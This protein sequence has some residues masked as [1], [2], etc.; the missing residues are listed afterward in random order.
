MLR[1]FSETSKEKLL[2]MVW[3]VENDEIC[4][5]TDWIGDRWCDYEDWL[6]DLGLVGYINDINAYHKKVIDKNNATYSAINRIF[7]EVNNV[8]V[9][10]WGIF[11]NIELL[12]EEQRI[13][14]SELSS[15]V[16]PKNKK[17]NTV[18][19]EHQLSDGV[20]NIKCLSKICKEEND[21]TEK[22]VEAFRN[23]D[24][25]VENYWSVFTEYVGN[26]AENYV[27]RFEEYKSLPE[28]IVGWYE[29]FQEDLY[30]DYDNLKSF[31]EDV[32]TERNWTKPNLLPDDC[33]DFFD[34]LSDCQ[35]I[36]DIAKELE[37]Y[38]QTGDGWKAYKEIGLSI[39][40]K[41]V[42]EGNKWL[43]KVDNLKY[44]GIDKQIQSVLVDTIIKMP[45]KYIDGIINYAENGVGTAGSIVVDSTVGALLESTGD[46]AKPIY[47]AST[48]VTYPVVDQI[49]EAVGY[50]LSS[51]Y[52]R[53]TGK[54]GLEGVFS[55]QKELWVD[56]V[57]EGAM[58]KAGQLV[59]DFYEG[60]GKGWK[61]WKSGMKLI[62]GRK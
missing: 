16:T 27:K 20:K 44:I 62:F 57:Y 50:D 21:A 24:S 29:W 3:Q 42:K 34:T 51:E 30:E 26:K 23:T 60:V 11:H 35:L 41:I 38:Y 61:S 47:M 17:F 37:E 8:D 2:N 33:E 56:I 28:A 45:D 25:I 4:F 6:T 55:A 43:D 9:S 52:E 13:F 39:F 49:C 46:A 22:E 19:I 54:K 59:D 14:I 7:E 40:G 36:I 53:L 12:L 58:D 31:I 15:I 5:F 18:T 32:L 10:Y 48:A 1:D